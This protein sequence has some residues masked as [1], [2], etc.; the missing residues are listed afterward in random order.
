MRY[1][2][3]LLLAGVIAMNWDTIKRELSPAPPLAQQQAQG[4]ILYAT[5]WCG[6]CK[7]AR[8]FFREHNIAYTEHDIEKSSQGRAQYEQLRGKGVPL[9][10][11]DGEVLRGYNP[12]KM[13][14]LLDIQ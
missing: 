4:V 1:G 8:E 9:V 14:Q 3:L 12:G 6:Y 5:S 2:I 13:K 7:K 11:I 10:L